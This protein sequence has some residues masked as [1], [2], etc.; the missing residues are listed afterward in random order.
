MIAALRLPETQAALP[1][2]LLTPVERALL[3][4]M[5]GG[6]SLS[7]ASASL[8]LSQADAHSTITHLQA[9]C[10]VSSLTRLIVVA[11]LKAWV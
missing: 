2:M 6:Y 11:I 7:E 8:G 1:K 10:G 9:R 4:L 3:R 5:V